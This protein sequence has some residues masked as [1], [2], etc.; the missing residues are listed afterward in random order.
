VKAA[1]RQRISGARPGRDAQL[2][3][4]G[5]AA[6]SP[7]KTTKR[8]RR[9]LLPIIS[10]VVFLALWQWVGGR[11]NPIPLSTPTSVARSFVDIT[12]E[13]ILGPAV[14]RAIEVLLVG[15]GISI[16]VG[17]ALGVLMG[18]SQTAYPIINPFVSFFQATSLIALTPLVVIWTLIKR[19]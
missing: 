12:R 7:R 5:S 1:R 13:G 3:S 16:V 14:L 4:T 17:I 10:V 9:W 18:R 8:V 2:Q 6:V 11:V 15:F 19:A